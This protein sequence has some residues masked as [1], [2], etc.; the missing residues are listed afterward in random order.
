MACLKKATVSSGINLFTQNG[1][2]NIAI[3]CVTSIRNELEC[4]MQFSE[5]AAVDSRRVTV[6]EVNE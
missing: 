4:P 1:F 6:M 5:G 3:L 2:Y